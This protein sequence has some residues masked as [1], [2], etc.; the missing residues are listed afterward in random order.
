MRND[1]FLSQFSLTK[2]K[3]V[4]FVSQKLFSLET[5][6]LNTFQFPLN[7]HKITGV[8]KSTIIVTNSLDKL[9]NGISFFYFFVPTTF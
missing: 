2:L 9:S 8:L 4:I 6:V 3:N 7:A 1:N 5:N